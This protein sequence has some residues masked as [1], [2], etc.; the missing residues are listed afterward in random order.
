M[1]DVKLLYVDLSLHSIN[2]QENGSVI[3]HVVSSQ[4]YAEHTLLK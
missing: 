2:I 3:D 1:H 4:P